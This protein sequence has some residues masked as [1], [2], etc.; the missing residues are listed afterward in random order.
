[1]YG[2]AI[3]CIN[4]VEQVEVLLNQFEWKS[5]DSPTET[6][7][8]EKQS[9]RPDPQGLACEAAARAAHKTSRGRGYTH[10]VSALPVRW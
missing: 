8:P 5:R 6:A 1:M 7:T 2:R 10:S 9:R 3:I 4:L